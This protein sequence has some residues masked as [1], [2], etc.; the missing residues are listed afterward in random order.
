MKHYHLEC[1]GT[2]KIF[3]DDGLLLSGPGSDRPALLRTVY[4]ERQLQLREDQ[5][6]IFRYAGWLPVSRMLTSPGGPVTYLSRHL[7][8]HL[9]LDQLYITFSGYWPAIGAQMRTGSFKECEAYS[10]CARFPVTSG[11]VLVVASAGN[12][13]RAFIKVASEHNIPLVAVVPQAC[14]ASLWQE[15]RPQPW[16]KLVAAGGDADYFDAIRL[17]DQIGQIEGF[18][19]E[20][21]AKNVA[22]RDGMGTTVLSAAALIGQIPDVYYQAIGSGTGAIA[23]YEA[24]LRLL[25]DGRYGQANLCLQLAQN[26]PFLPIYQ[27]WQNRCREIETLSPETARLQASQID[28]TVLANRKPPYGLAGGLYDALQATG[29]NVASIGNTELRQAQAL[30]QELEGCDIS[31]ESGVALAAL[32]QR[33]DAGLERRDRCIMLNI[34]GGGLEQIKSDL[35]PIMLEPDLIIPL[36]K[37]GT[38]GTSR[39]MSG[40]KQQIIDSL[41]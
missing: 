37:I 2:G 26:A 16:V 7:A 20:G 23:A 25:G 27:A 29:G 8:R 12:T 22:R 24:G 30:F 18:Q 38:E 36:D 35:K 28:A 34:T 32:Q 40:L 3:A 10:V 6:G 9:G 41:G 1:Q 17:A 19:P 13:A 39:Q 33:L 21:G 5:P 15:R 14:L 11:S 4:A 31:P